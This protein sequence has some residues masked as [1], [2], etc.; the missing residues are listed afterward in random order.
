MTER[1]ALSTQ[2]GGE[3]PD[4]PTFGA[5]FLAEYKRMGG[6][7]VGFSY[8]EIQAV[9]A[10]DRE[11]LVTTLRKALPLISYAAIQRIRT[12][13]TPEQLARD[14]RQEQQVAAA[15]A[16]VGLFAMF[17]IFAALS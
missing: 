15:A 4:E 7:L 9:K 10:C 13:E 16:P 6:G 14:L 2:Q 3:A 17:A 1:E 11:Q 12:V 5:R 8:S